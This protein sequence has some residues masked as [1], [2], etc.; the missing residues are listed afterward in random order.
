MINDVSPEYNLG[1]KDGIALSNETVRQL[2]EK[3][4]ENKQKE[5]SKNTNITQ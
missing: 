5:T 2:L 4:K 3:N 1:V